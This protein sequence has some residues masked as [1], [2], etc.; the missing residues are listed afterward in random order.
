MKEIS[1]EEK[2]LNEYAKLSK[3]QIL[4]NNFLYKK[5]EYLAD[6]NK[7]T[8]KILEELFSKHNKEEI[9][10]L[11]NYKNK[12][13]ID[14]DNFIKEYEKLNN[15]YN[16]LD[17][18]YENNIPMIKT[19][20]LEEKK[21]FCLDFIK[22]EKNDI[23]K[24]LNNSIKQS[25]K[26]GLYREKKR[27]TLVKKEKGD[28]EM[29]RYYTN[30]QCSLLF[31]LK[32]CNEI[33][34]KI[35]KYNSK[36][37]ELLNNINLLNKYIS[38][39]DNK[40]KINNKQQKN[41]T[42]RKNKKII[43]ESKKQTL[44]SV[45]LP[46]NKEN[47]LEDNHKNNSKDDN[48]NYN[49][50]RKKRKN[51]IINE[52]KNLDNLFETSIQ[53]IDIEQEINSDEDGLFENKFVN[54]KNLSIDYLKNIQNSI[55]KL[56][57]GLIEYNKKYNNEIDV[58]SL[59]RRKF[60]YKSMKNK[61]KE[62]KQ[63][64]EKINITLNYLKKKIDDFKKLNEKTVDKYKGMKSIINLNNSISNINPNFI[65]NS[66][67]IGN[68]EDTK[69][70]E[71]TSILDGADEIEE[72][73]IDVQDNEKS[74]EMKETKDTKKEDEEERKILN[75]NLKSTRKIIKGSNFFIIKNHLKSSKN[76]KKFLKRY[77]S[78]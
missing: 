71:P 21:C 28:K 54:K 18:I 32:K 63:K 60:K 44:K 22:T 74:D 9:S 66:L 24:S 8:K 23:I 55:P 11:E 3:E 5:L 72:E 59:Q 62:M 47:V 65:V 49:G 61:I 52:F 67:N 39:N 7:I 77:H 35:K 76:R 78:K 29:E 26:F 37:E 38:N 13:K 56:K 40:T 1:E 19:I 51:K 73:E 58:Y 43:T 70:N 34:E 46:S 50:Y 75:I 30:M 17:N 53:D 27:D 68:T 2:Y 45:F 42:K 48:Y 14:N 31:E 10:I 57:F 12:I 41:K 25:K 20:M 69:G 16:S 64:K 4:L 6:Y 33:N 36:K 15:K